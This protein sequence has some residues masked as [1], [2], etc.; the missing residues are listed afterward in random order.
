MK[1]VKEKLKDV[2]TASLD[3]LFPPSCS[4]CKKITGGSNRFL[5]MEC[6][7]QLKFIKIPY[8]TCCGKTFSSGIDNHLCGD[9]LKSSWNFDK[10]RSLFVYEEIIASLIHGLKYSGNMTGLET[11]QYLS[12][13]SPVLE[14]LNIPDF[15]VPVPLHIRRLRQRGFNQALLLARKLFPEEKDK[16]QYNILLRRMDTPTQTGLSGKER[17][18]NLKNAFIVKRTSEI[19]GKN[20]LILDDVFT[21]G[22]TVNECAKALKT[23]GCKRVEILTICRADKTLS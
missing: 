7:S 10:A 21:T 12:R 15:I 2:V 5:C 1:M 9:C 6:S 19:I 3:L 11:F 16:I 14:D 13:Q 17:R 4:Y 20:I 22:A 8:C 23:A 18:A